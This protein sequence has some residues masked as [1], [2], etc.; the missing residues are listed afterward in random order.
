MQTS[1]SVI[2][3]TTRLSSST[4][5]TTPQSCRH[6][7]SAQSLSESFGWHVRGSVVIKSLI[8]MDFSC[9]WAPSALRCQPRF[10]M[11]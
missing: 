10:T 6:M 4:T 5:G 1:R 3:P 8:F 11:R 2:M 7:M 9:V